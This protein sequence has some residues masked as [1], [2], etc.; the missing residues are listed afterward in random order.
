MVA[1]S[2]SQLSQGN[3]ASRFV[4]KGRVLGRVFGGFRL[5]GGAALVL[6][7]SASASP[8]KILPHTDPPATRWTKPTGNAR[9]DGADSNFCKFS[10]AFIS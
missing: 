4:R 7:L 3:S 9:H 2:S 1:L 5:G 8:V 6:T 10:R